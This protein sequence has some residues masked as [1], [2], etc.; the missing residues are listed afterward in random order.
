MTSYPCG[1]RE[2]AYALS[3]ACIDGDYIPVGWSAHAVALVVPDSQNT[4]SPERR[5][6]FHV[7]PLALLP[8]VQISTSP[9]PPLPCPWIFYVRVLAPRHTEPRHTET[10]LKYLWTRL[11]YHFVTCTLMRHRLRKGA[12]SVCVLR[13]MGIC[14]M[15]KM[16]GNKAT[17]AKEREQHRAYRFL[18]AR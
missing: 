2:R 6:S 3:R 9:L 13:N 14:N 11:K 5:S 1:S 12:G 17:I 15:T 10:N 16:K 8:R 18:V 7:L 4:I